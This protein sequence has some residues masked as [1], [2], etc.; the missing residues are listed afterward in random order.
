MK[1][2]DGE[3]EDLQ[4]QFYDFKK[5]IENEGGKVIQEIKKCSRENDNLVDWLKLYDNQIKSYQKEIYNLNVKLYLSSPSQSSQPPQSTQPPQKSV[6]PLH[7]NSQPP[8]Q[9]VIP[10]HNNSQPPQQSVI[11]LQNNSQPPQQSILLSNSSNLPS[12]KFKSLADYF[13]NQ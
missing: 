9:S 4:I 5:M 7:N 8:Q 11:P 1:K 12:P 10:L 6:I 3:I 13:K 2:K